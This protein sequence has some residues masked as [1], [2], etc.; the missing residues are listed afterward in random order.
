M[1][2]ASLA[3]FFGCGPPLNINTAFTARDVGLPAPGDTIGATPEP[4]TVQVRYFSFS[5]TVSVVAW[6]SSEAGYGLR[7]WMRRD[8]SLIRD[9]R[10]YV[11]TFYEPAVRAY[12][13]A[14][15]PPRK[16]RMTGISRDVYACY[17]GER[18]SPPETYGARIPDELLRA[19]RDSVAVTFYG[20]GRELTVTV[21][22]DLIDAYLTAIDSVRAQLRRRG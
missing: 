16:L 18:C 9:H 10:I 12:P 5:P 11:S 14:A 3:G 8:G 6:A 20:R 4:A 22:R 15:V 13:H 2:T 17:F 21:R 7:A 1:L 19:S